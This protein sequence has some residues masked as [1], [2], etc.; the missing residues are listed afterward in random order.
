MKIAVFA[1]DGIGPEVTAQAVR[2]LDKLAIAG[3]EMVE[4][5]VGGAAYYKHGHPLPEAT[6]DIARSVDGILFGAVGDFSC[7]HLERAA[8]GTGHSGPAQGTFAVRQ[9]APG[10]ALPRP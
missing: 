7:D 8:P 3:L 2:V 1:G 4:G 6:K 10:N 5:D 9:P